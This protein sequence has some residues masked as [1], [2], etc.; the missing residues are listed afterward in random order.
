MTPERLAALAP[1]RGAAVQ[2]VLLRASEPAGVARA[3]LAVA[4]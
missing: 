2:S 3:F 1:C 4:R